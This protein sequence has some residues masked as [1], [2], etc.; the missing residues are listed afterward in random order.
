MEFR[1][2][3]W[4]GSKCVYRVPAPLAPD[5]E[6]R[7]TQQSHPSMLNGLG[8]HYG[9]FKVHSP[10]DTIWI[11]PHVA[12]P[13]QRE[14]PACPPRACRV[15]SGRD[16]VVLSITYSVSPRD[17]VG[18][19]NSGRWLSMP[20]GCHSWVTWVTPP[21]VAAA[22]ARGP[23]TPAT[24]VPSVLGATGRVLAG[25]PRTVP[26]HVGTRTGS[27]CVRV[28]LRR[29]APCGAPEPIRAHTRPARARCARRA[30]A[31]GAQ[32]A[33]L[34]R[35]PPPQPPALLPLLIPPVQGLLSLL[36]EN[37]L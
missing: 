7:R 3:V 13:R 34:P 36:L 18:A 35:T 29:G 1:C 10:L 19:R 22:P 9:R 15:C 21:W 20:T 25:A 16:W 24:C 6:A 31:G 11:P 12:P 28:V 14:A 32:D 30:R 17:H 37:S 4:R 2:V 8:V 5:G 33:W 27:I 23:T 26:P